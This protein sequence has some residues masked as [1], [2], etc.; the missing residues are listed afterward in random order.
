MSPFRPF[1]V[2]PLV[3]FSAIV[4][5]LAPNAAAAP[6]VLI[7]AAT[8]WAPDDTGTVTLPVLVVMRDAVLTVPIVR[9]ATLVKLK[10]WFG[11][12][13]TTARLPILL[14]VLPNEA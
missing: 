6:I 10:A 5:A 1:S 14:A 12:V 11:P 2:T 3:A 9:S 8:V 7:G 13:S 4:P